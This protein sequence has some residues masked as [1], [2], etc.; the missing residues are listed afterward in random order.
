VRAQPVTGYELIDLLSGGEVQT[1]RGKDSRGADVV[2]KQFPQK[3][4]VAFTARTGSLARLESSHVATLLGRGQAGDRLFAVRD[5]FAAGSLRDLAP[6]FDT[7][8][9]LRACAEIARGLEHAHLHG[10]VHGA[11]KP[12]N[13]V[14]TD[15]RRALLVD[16]SIAAAAP[17]SFSPPESPTD[18]RS[19]QWALAAVAGFLLV[20][21][22]PSAGETIS[23][24]AALD[25]ALQR[26][27]APSLTERFRRIDELASA[28][29]S[30]AGST[31]GEGADVRVERKENVLRVHVAGRWTPGVIEACLRDID[32]AMLRFPTVSAIGYVF[33][34]VGGN[35]SQAIDAIGDLHRRHRTRL[36]RV[37]FVSHSPQARGA[38][39][40]I[41]TRGGL[42]WRTFASPDMMDP[43]LR[44]GAA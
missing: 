29:E 22:V 43:W 12:E 8:S 9:K 24:D 11:V 31:T 1:W 33:D 18:P 14:F 23:S 37:G 7:R 21:H 32:H 41:G 3:H 6:T 28:L 2:I 4:L 44:G 26:A 19:D 10:L 16:F 39:I 27:I 25:R 34:A 20:G 17:G 38:C 15:D 36:G 5:Y 42:E 40:L 30:A 13:I 35:H